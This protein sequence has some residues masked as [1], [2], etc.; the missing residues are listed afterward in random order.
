MTITIEGAFKN[1]LIVPDQPV[2]LAEGTRLRIQLTPCNGEIKSC[3]GAA[4]VAD[5]IL[6]VIGIGSSG[7]RDGAE[8]HDHYIYG[9]PKKDSR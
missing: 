5:P 2:K 1:G 8:N 7:V 4:D 3:A 9:L 6:E